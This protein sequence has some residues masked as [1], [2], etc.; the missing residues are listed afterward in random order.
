MSTGDL[1]QREKS[2]GHVGNEIERNLCKIV[3]LEFHMKGQFVE[4]ISGEGERCRNQ[5]K[6]GEYHYREDLSIVICLEFVTVPHQEFFSL[7]KHKR[8]DDLNLNSSP[9]LSPA[10]HY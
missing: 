5:K 6:R 8:F 9:E 2:L 10:P 1:H 3:K 4:P 7:N